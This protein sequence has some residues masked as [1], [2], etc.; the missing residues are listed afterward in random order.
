MCRLI[1]SDVVCKDV[2]YFMLTLI[3]FRVFFE[4]WWIEQSPQWQA[5]VKELINSGR[6]EFV[7]GIK[8][9]DRD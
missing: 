3:F 9:T 8:K 5:Q 6:L 2:F 4:M 1:L 7:G